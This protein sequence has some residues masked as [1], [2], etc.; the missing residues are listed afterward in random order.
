MV[1]SETICF[2]RIA[3]TVKGGVETTETVKIAKA[4]GAGAEN[5]KGSKMP[6]IGMIGFST[7][8]A[9]DIHKIR[10]HSRPPC[11]YSGVMDSRCV[12]ELIRP[13]LS[14]QPMFYDP[15]VSELI[16][17]LYYDNPHVAQLE[18]KR[19]LCHETQNL[20]AMEGNIDTLIIATPGFDFVAENI[21]EEFQCE[22][23]SLSKL[24]TDYCL[25]RR[26]RLKKIGI[27]GT[28]LDVHTDNQIVQALKWAEQVEALPVDLAKQVAYGIEKRFTLKVLSDGKYMSATDYILG[29]AEKMQTEH[30]LDAMIVCNPELHEIA[31][32]LR[33]CCPKLEVIDATEMS[34]MAADQC[35]ERTSVSVEADAKGT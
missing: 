26:N 7:A 14:D 8:Y 13:N 28:P 5:S 18:I 1:T 25:E 32:M 24:I 15:R 2:E 23:I 19:V 20:F 34:W 30:Q 3:E 6:R 33:R 21:S 10:R 12:R 4:T 31:L 29:L 9:I 17:Q 35:F 11:E 27:F 22:V 16:Q